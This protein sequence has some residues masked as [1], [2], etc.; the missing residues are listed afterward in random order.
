[1]PDGAPRLQL[2]GE[3]VLDEA[4]LIREPA[5]RLLRGDSI[6]SVLRD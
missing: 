2:S 3:I 5:G 6:R 1:M 4:A